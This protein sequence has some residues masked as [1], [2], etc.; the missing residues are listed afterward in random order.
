MATMSPLRRRMIED[1]T[2]RNLSPATQRSYLNAV[3]KFSRHFGRSPDR[4]GLD[5]VHAFQV[6]LVAN[7]LS[8]PA[9][10]QIVCALRFFYGVTLGQPTIPERIAYARQPQKLPVVLSGEEVVRLLEAVASLK[11]RTALTT[12]YATGLRV[13][14]V[15]RLQIGDIDSQRMVIRVEQGSGR[16]YRASL[17]HFAPNKNEAYG[18]SP[19]TYQ[20]YHLIDMAAE[21]GVHEAEKWV[22]ENNRDK[23]WFFPWFDYGGSIWG[24]T[25]ILLNNNYWYQKPDYWD[26]VKANVEFIYQKGIISKDQW[27]MWN[28]WFKEKDKYVNIPESQYP[29]EHKGLLQQLDQARAQQAEVMGWK[30]P[31]EPLFKELWEMGYRAAPAPAPAITPTPAPTAPRQ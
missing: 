10:N 18:Y 21:K 19:M 1:M 2:V 8:W 13:S 31:G 5:E 14:E 11:S 17:M 22:K 6:H 25:N 28:E 26:R 27:D 12:V 4:L 23:V 7:G 20:T 15:V 16:V 30:M 29:P 3:S 24:R 9:L